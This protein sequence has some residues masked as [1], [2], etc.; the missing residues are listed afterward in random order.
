MVV[1]FRSTPV[2]Q[3]AA[4]VAVL[5]MVFAALV[6]SLPGPFDA[7]ALFKWASTEGRAIIALYAMAVGASL[8][9]PTAG[10]TMVRRIV[11]VVSVTLLLGL[12]SHE[13]H[14]GPP[15]YDHRSRKLMHG[16]TSSHHVA[17]FLGAGLVLVAI[18]MPRLFRPWV[19]VSAVTGG[20]L[21]VALTASRS[22]F[23]GLAVGLVVVL[24]HQLDRRRFVVVMTATVIALSGLFML[25]PRFRQ[26]VEVVTRPEFISEVA[27]AFDT[28]TKRGARQLSDSGV[29]ANMLIRFALWGAEFDVVK[30]SPLVGIGRFRLN[31]DVTAMSGIDGVLLVATDGER[32]HTHGQPHNMYVF[33]LSETGI[34]GLALFAAPYMM[35]VRATRRRLIADDDSPTGDNSDSDGSLET[36][37]RSSEHDPVPGWSSWLQRHQES[38]PTN[39]EW[40]A[41]SRGVLAFGLAI[42]MFSA[43]L[44]TTGLGLFTNLVVFAG[45]AVYGRADEEIPVSIPAGSEST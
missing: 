2:T 38:L 37:S 39:D 41:C 29:E 42:G 9:S 43:A 15:L 33:L 40:R 35:A 5:W 17:G 26:T 18:A 44:M 20:V 23:V 31:D 1:R 11:L 4:M 45:A 24:A 10:A 36:S 6:G 7:N 30:Q 19:R 13:F 32:R 8:R 34:V 3:V 25:V 27:E 28:G 21:T 14:I 22:A 12:I 16:L